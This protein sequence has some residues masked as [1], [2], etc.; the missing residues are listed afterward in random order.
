MDEEELDYGPEEEELVLVKDQRIKVIDTHF[1]WDKFFLQ[2][3]FSGLPSYTWEEK[4]NEKFQI[5]YLI[6]NFVFPSRWKA[7]LNSELLSKVRSIKHTIGIHPKIAGNQVGQLLKELKKRIP[8]KFMAIGE[9]GLDVSQGD[10][11][12]RE[13]IK[14]LRVQLE[15]A[16]SNYLPVVTHCRGGENIASRY[17]DIMTESLDRGHGVHWHCFSE[18]KKKYENI[19]RCLP[20]TKF[21][22]SP[23]LL[24]DDKYPQLRSQVC[25]MQLEDIILESD[26]PYI[27]P[28]NYED[29][30]PLLIK[31]IIQKLA[32]MFNTS[33]REIAEIT[34]RNAH[35]LYKFE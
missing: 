13:Q 10:K 12:L 11:D 8:G 26:S 34:T 31:A 28:K 21:G 24:M 15:L 4:G 20:N 27:H 9:Y 18:D 35:Q 3:R 14:V 2:A 33:G 19:K 30:S 29:N 5:R 7:C 25:E 1:H 22:I 6:S 32:I 17:L 16:K 23:L